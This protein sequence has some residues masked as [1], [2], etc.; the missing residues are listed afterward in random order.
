M[1]EKRERKHNFIEVENEINYGES[2]VKKSRAE[3]LISFCHF[4]I[5]VAYWF[6]WFVLAVKLNFFLCA[7]AVLKIIK[8]SSNT[9]NFQQI[10]YI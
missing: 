6:W 4:T 2:K 7:Y 9:L 8:M 10:W 5:D 3:N 1:K